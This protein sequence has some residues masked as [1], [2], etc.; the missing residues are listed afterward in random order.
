MVLQLVMSTDSGRTPAWASPCTCN[1]LSLGCGNG[2]PCHINRKFPSCSSPSPLLHALSALPLISPA[3][4]RLQEC[5]HTS[6]VVFQLVMPTDSSVRG[7]PPVPGAD[8]FRPA[9]AMAAPATFAVFTLPPIIHTVTDHNKCGMSLATPVPSWT[10]CTRD[11]Q[12]LTYHHIV[13]LPTGARLHSLPLPPRSLCC[14]YTGG[15]YTADALQHDG[16]WL[17]FNDAE[18][19]AVPLDAVLSER[20]YLLF[21]Q[22]V[23]HQHA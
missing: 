17:R 2:S 13:T 12:L 21:Y 6:P 20:P 5:C 1:R 3:S 10:G 4:Q 16:R 9:A 8:T 19:D 22:R 23:R 18:V 14:P 11:C 7:T 15:H